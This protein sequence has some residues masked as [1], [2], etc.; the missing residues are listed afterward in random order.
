M[1]SDDE[2][3]TP[4]SGRS[5]IVTRST[6]SATPRPSYVPPPSGIC[7]FIV[8]FVVYVYIGYVTTDNESDDAPWMS[9]HPPARR[10][11]TFKAEDH[12]ETPVPPPGATVSF[13]SSTSVGSTSSSS[14]SGSSTPA[15]TQPAFHPYFPSADMLLDPLFD[16]ERL[17]AWEKVLHEQSTTIGYVRVCLNQRRA[18]ERNILAINAARV[19][20]DRAEAD[21]RRTI[22]RVKVQ[23]DR[24]S[25][26]SSNSGVTYMTINYVAGKYYRA[27]V[28][29]YHYPAPHVCT[30]CL[31]SEISEEDALEEEGAP[32]IACLNEQCVSRL[33]VNCFDQLA[34]KEC[35]TCRSRYY[36]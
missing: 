8:I 7:L 13:S 17:E 25:H 1:I 32:M 4:P 30:L 3:V 34:L 29:A 10:A 16:E 14:S 9:S 20:L 28:R 2:L 31:L 15:I 33:C 21:V 27:G 23:Q 24:L 35:P 6:T 18:I 12:P 26:L 19:A 36:K 11:L 22:C 5:T